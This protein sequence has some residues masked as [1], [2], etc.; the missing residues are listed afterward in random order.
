MRRRSQNIHE[1]FLR[2]IWSKQ[3]LRGPLEVVDERLLTVFDVGRLNSGGGPDFCDAKIKIGGVTYKGDIE[4][5][6]TVFDWL[7]HQHQEDTHYNKVVLHVVLESS[8]NDPPTYVCSKREVPVLVLGTF[9]SDSIHTIW[10]KAML[11]ERAQ[12]MRTIP[13]FENNNSITGDQLQRALTKLSVERLELKLRR[14]EEQLKQLA[15]E[16]RMTVREQ[17]YLYGE[18][19]QEESPDEI[20]PPQPELTQKDFSHKE[21]WEQ[22]LYEGVMEGLGYSNNREPFIRLARSI[23]LEKM[24]EW[25]FVRKDLRREALLF[26]AAGLIPRIKTVKEKASLNYVRRLAQIWKELRLEY[27]SEILHPADWQ[28]FP[29]RPSNF[30][31]L[32]LAAASALLDKFMFD[33]LFRHIIQ[34]L[35]SYNT[36]EH[37]EQAM[38]HLFM[39]EPHEF[40]G[41]HYNLHESSSQTITALGTTRIREIIINAVLPLALFYA[42]TFKES[43]VREGTLHVYR[44]MP[45]MENNSIIRVMKAQLLKGKLALD[46]VSTQQAS[47]QLYKY[48]CTANRCQDCG[49][50]AFL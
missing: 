6:R 7:Q 9:L 33:D 38:L 22:V 23:T 19:P 30:P 5:H 28:F 40:W 13:C 39:I 26:G 36:A 27:R 15:F 46:S 2:H 25:K 4:I 10:R 18:P 21:L 44:S 35:K 8:S 42:R 11:D 29:T 3:Y 49:I 43:G 17:L 32:R 1:R 48:Y 31:I 41:H 20:P 12:R 47:I 24:R 45:A 34:L 37:K 14:F 16:R 50:H